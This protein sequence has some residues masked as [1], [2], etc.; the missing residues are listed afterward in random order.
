MQYRQEINQRNNKLASSLKCDKNYKRSQTE[1]K[2]LN[3][4]AVEGLKK[5][6][7]TQLTAL[8]RFF[9]PTQNFIFFALPFSTAATMEIIYA[10]T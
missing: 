7:K 4:K 3:S 6:N 8:L 10:N 2:Y 1:P 5:N 9:R